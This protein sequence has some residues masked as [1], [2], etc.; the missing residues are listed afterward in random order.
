MLQKLLIG[1]ALFVG[2]S[3]GWQMRSTWSLMGQVRA[4]RRVVETMARQAA[5]STAADARHQRQ[6]AAARSVY[7]TLYREVP[8]Y[9]P[10]TT[11][12]R[13]DVPLGLV[14]L[15]DAAAL[16]VPAVP[17]PAGRPHDAPAGLGLDTVA[18]SVVD[19]DETCNAVRDQLVSLQDWV[20][21]QEEP[22]G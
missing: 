20:R 14:R 11:V 8:V 22:A 13:C 9:V 21:E 7:R 16:G 2:L 15:L 18:R 17:D 1:A 10:Q 6:A 12:A 3:V 4:E 5:V 19:N